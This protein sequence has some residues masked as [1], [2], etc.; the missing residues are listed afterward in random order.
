M[1]KTMTDALSIPTFGY[2]DDYEA[3][4]LIAMRKE[5]KKSNEKLTMLPFFIKA[6][7]IALKDYPLMNIN[8]NPETDDQGYIKEYV[9]K[10]NHNIAVAINSKHGLVVPVIK[11]VQNLSIVDINNKLLEF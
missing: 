4:K 6:C 9:I 7:S 2:M 5:L 1:T 3:G 10:S 8:V 11:Q